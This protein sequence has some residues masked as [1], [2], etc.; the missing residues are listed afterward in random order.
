VVVVSRRAEPAAR[1]RTVDW[2]EVAGEIEGADAVVNLAGI[3]I[4]GPRWTTRRKEAIRSSRVDTTRTLAEA[5]SAAAGPPSVFVT[6]SGVDYYGDRG[7]ETVDESSPPGR[8]F[9]AGVCVEWEAAAAA[10]PTRHVAVRTALVIGRGAQAVTL[11][12]LPFRLFVGGPLG[13]GRQWFSWVH[14]DDLVAI[15]RRALDDE[16]LAGPVNAVAPEQL[17]QREAARA[18]GAVLHRPALLAA[19]AVALRAALGE[20][21]DLLLHS[22]RAVSA[23]LEGLEFRYPRLEPALTDA[24]R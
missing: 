3:S 4:G 15:Y 19:P 9:L 1:A 2:P 20:Q 5:I 11:M 23:R 8:S 12:A 13:S 16:S 22:R 14:L 18:F 10:S 7:D 6:A 21:A 24:L 17:R